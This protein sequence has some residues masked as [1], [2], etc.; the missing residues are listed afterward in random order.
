MEAPAR[1][2]GM[3]R[4]AHEK[5]ASEAA[6]WVEAW[7][8]HLR[9][10]FNSRAL[11]SVRIYGGEPITL[12]HVY[13][14]DGG[15]LVLVMPCEHER[16]GHDHGHDHGPEHHRISPA[17]LPPHP[18]AKSPE[19]HGDAPPPHHHD[20]GTAPPH[21]HVDKAADRNQEITRPDE[22]AGLAHGPEGDCPGGAELWIASPAQAVFE[23]RSIDVGKLCTGLGYL[24]LSRTPVM[25]IARSTELPPKRDHHERV[26]F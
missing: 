10:R 24:G 26:D 2:T 11:V 19:G 4:G 12:S 15:G 17:A 5:D 7:A 23:A 9:K 13:A 8:D 25:L 22:A 21:H 3:P 1:V 20:A 6:R 14:L 16:A 18:H